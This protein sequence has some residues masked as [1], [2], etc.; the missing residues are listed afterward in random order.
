MKISNEIIRVKFSDG[1]Y[2]KQEKVDY[3]R[4]KIINIYIVYKLTP[5]I[6]TENGL[7]Q[8]NG[9]FGNLK[10]EILKI[11]YIIDTMMV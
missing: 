10:M 5:T 3:I 2:F 4:N 11:L 7:V 8:V 6:I 9:L 1:D